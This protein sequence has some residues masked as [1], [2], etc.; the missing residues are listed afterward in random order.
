MPVDYA[1][2]AE[3][4]LVRSHFSGVVTFSEVA[5]LAAKLRD[6]PEFAP[7]F[8]ELITFAADV[9]VRLKLG[10]FTFLLT[11]D[12]FSETSKRAFVIPSRGAV[13]GVIRIYESVRDES[14]NVRIFATED[15]ALRWLNERANVA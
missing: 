3:G 9:D 11:V 12:A 6:D 13:Y 14:P 1:V 4:H 15:E 10:D 7:D 8:A 5:T 2:N